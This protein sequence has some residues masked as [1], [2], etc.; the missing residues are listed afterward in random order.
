MT[1]TREGVQPALALAWDI[2]NDEEAEDES[3]VCRTYM[4]RRGEE[5][6]NG[7]WRRD[8]RCC[9]GGAPRSRNQGRWTEEVATAVGE[10]RGAKKMIEGI[11][12]NGEHP[13]TGLRHMYDQKKKAA[14]RAVDRARRSMEEALYR[15]LDEDGG[16]KMIFKMARDRTEDGR[17]V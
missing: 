6:G 14:R 7:R 9:T 1:R 5:N 10:K 16:K 2:V 3:N 15:K 12:D 13:S 11:R 8:T 4:R 17:D